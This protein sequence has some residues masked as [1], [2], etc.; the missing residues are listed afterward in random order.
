MHNFAIGV[1]LA[2]TLIKP[3]LPALLSSQLILLLLKLFGGIAW[4]WIIVLS[5]LWVPATII[6]AICGVFALL[7][8]F[9]D[10]RS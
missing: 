3:I 5:P 1:F 9:N 7:V 6:V 4:S 2:V 8:Y 10:N